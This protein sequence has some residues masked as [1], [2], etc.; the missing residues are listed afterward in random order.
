M[1]SAWLNASSSINDKRPSRVANG[2]R[3]S[4]VAIV[5][6]VAAACRA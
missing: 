5:G 2:K 4:R 6:F 3:P 1:V